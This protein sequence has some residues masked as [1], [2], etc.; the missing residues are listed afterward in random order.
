LF[1]KANPVEM[2]IPTPWRKHDRP[3][4]WVI[5]QQYSSSHLRAFIGQKENKIDMLLKKCYIT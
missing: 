3:T 4:T 5:T 2:Q 1:T